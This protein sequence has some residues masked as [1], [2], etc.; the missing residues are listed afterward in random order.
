MGEMINA[1]KKLSGRARHR[2]RMILKCTLKKS[3][4][5]VWN[6]FISLRTQNRGE[7]CEHDNEN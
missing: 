1:C 6:G 5:K 3:S 7:Y 2:W 4:A